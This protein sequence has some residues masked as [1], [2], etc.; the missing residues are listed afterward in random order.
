MTGRRAVLA[1]VA[2]G[3]VAL[4]LMLGL[5]PRSWQGL[6]L[7]PSA[8]NVVPFVGLDSAII[9]TV[10]AEEGL[11]PGVEGSVLFVRLVS[12]EGSTVLDRPF[13]WPADQQR[14]SPGQYA[15][16]VYWRGCNGNCGDLSDENSF[17]EEGVSV[18]SGGRIRVTVTPSQLSPG[19]QCTVAT[20]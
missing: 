8:A 5:V 15:L 12:P 1:A 14:I 9:E 19:S 18:A 10:G 6:P 11:T 7:D 17:C 13:E 16:N 3:G 20:D 2:L 4:I